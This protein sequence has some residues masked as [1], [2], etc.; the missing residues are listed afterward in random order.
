[1][2]ESKGNE[3]IV[4]LADTP[5]Y[6]SL[7][8]AMKIRKYVKQRNVSQLPKTVQKIISDQQDEAGKYELSA[9][10]ELQNAIEGAQFYVDG[11]H[12]EIRAGNAKSKIDQSLEYLVAHVYSKLD[13]ITDNA[14][15]DVDIIAILTGAVTALPGMDRT[16]MLLLLWKNIW[17]CRM[18]KSCRLLWQMCKA[19]TVRFRMAGKKSTLLR[20]RHS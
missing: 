6:E 18:R 9:M 16:V 15:S 12:L 3:A 13:L 14:G 20:L 10:S 7:E 4:V 5:Y 8:S 19:N 2:A 1:M 17:K 11:E